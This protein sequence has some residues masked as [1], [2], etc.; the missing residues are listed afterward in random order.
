MTVKISIASDF[1]R[2]PAGRVI[3][4][5]PFSGESFR[6]KFLEPPIKNDKHITI[7]L[8]GTRGYGSSFLE[9]AFGGLIREGF[10]P[11]RVK[12]LITFKAS[13]QSLIQEILEYID[14]A[15]K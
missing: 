10:L 12:E 2:H 7:D 4:D 15:G 1:S 11:E 5:G 8:D 14:D 9:E 3:A 13:D 6:K